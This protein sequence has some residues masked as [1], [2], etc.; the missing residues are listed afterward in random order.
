MRLTGTALMVLVCS[1][2]EVLCHPTDQFNTPSPPNLVKRP[3]VL[4]P[5]KIPPSGKPTT[6][7]GRDVSSQ[8]LGVENKGLSP[9]TK[10]STPQT[11]DTIP[12][13]GE[14]HTKNK[15]QN[16][17]SAWVPANASEGGDGS[18]EDVVSL[19]AARQPSSPLSDSSFLRPARP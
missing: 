13:S 11:S 8:L 4:L 14:N 17:E 2:S 12:L 1:S 5:T 9:D 15:R 7:Q 3:A 19:A 16:E 6:S 18:K 10:S